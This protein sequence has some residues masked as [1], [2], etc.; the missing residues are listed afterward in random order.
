M[1]VIEPGALT[2]R[3]VR[4]NQAYTTSLCITN[5]LTASVEFSLR[6]SAPRYIVT[7]GKVTLQGGQSIV[8]SVRLFLSHYPNY[9]KG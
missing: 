6:P 3:D 7:P 9:S 2:F 1:L 4:L 8:V 5:P